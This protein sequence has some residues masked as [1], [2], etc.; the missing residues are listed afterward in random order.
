MKR[1]EPKGIDVFLFPPL[2]VLIA[3]A[4]TILAV[5]TSSFPET[6]FLLCH[7]GIHS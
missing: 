6:L 1:Q 7:A 3:C 5:M 4:A 2:L